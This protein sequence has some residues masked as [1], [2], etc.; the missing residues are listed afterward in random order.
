MLD[1][2]VGKSVPEEQV[3]GKV[4][5]GLGFERLGD[6]RPES[7]ERAHCRLVLVKL[8]EEE[9]G[10][11]GDSGTEWIHVVPLIPAPTAEDVPSGLV[12]GTG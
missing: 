5:P 11:Y 3:L 10:K 7:P 6:D 4:Y 9:V 8:V 12:D 1:A 2:K